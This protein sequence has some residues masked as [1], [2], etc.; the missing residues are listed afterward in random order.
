MSESVLAL[1]NR[2]RSEIYE[3]TLQGT[4]QYER[5]YKILLKHLDIARDLNQPIIVG[6]TFN[7][8]GIVEQY[9]GHSESA[10]VY[11]NQA[12]E[13]FAQINN[14]PLMSLIKNN[15]GELYRLA[16]DY[17]QALRF[18]EEAK[19]LL[20]GT[21]EDTIRSRALIDSNLGLTFLAMQNIPAA[22]RQLLSFLELVKDE[23]WLHMDALLEARCG[24]AEVFL[25][26][27]NYAEAWANA[28]LALHLASGRG[29]TV[30]LADIHFTRA[31]I[32]QADT[33]STLLPQMIYNEAREALNM[34][35]SQVSTA[36]ALYQEAL[37][38]QQRGNQERARQFAQ[39]AHAIFAE[40]GMEERAVHAAALV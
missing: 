14:I 33:S 2:I 23:T 4:I 15:L 6:R 22:K 21:E 9:M 26:E 30:V 35:T 8:L 39:E 13:T 34:Q 24:L 16:R 31:H 5:D 40:L 12:Y 7:M 20:V 27:Q 19:N 11:Y 37:Y 29:H 32:A 3:K 1:L 28:N 18:Y 17:P 10:V 38:Q 36:R 25:A